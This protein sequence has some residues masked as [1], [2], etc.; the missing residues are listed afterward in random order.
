VPFFA[1]GRHIDLQ[2]MQIELI[3]EDDVYPKKLK[4]VVSSPLADFIQENGFDCP[5][6]LLQLCVERIFKFCF[7]G[8]VY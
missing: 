4:V 7:E 8:F 3:I 1:F 6:K 2:K 5:Q